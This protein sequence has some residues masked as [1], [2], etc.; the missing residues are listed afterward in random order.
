L[1]YLHTQKPDEWSTEF[2]L[3]VFHGDAYMLQ[4]EVTFRGTLPQALTRALSYTAS[5]GQAA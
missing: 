3:L 4:E 5:L 2:S 1:I